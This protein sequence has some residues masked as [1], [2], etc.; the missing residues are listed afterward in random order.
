MPVDILKLTGDPIKLTSVEYS[1]YIK[2]RTEDSRHLN[3]LLIPGPDFLDI[4]GETQ[5]NQLIPGSSMQIER[6]YTPKGVVWKISVSMH[7]I[8]GVKADFVGAVY[9]LRRSSNSDIAWTLVDNDVKINNADQASGEDC[10]GHATA[11]GFSDFIPVVNKTD[12]GKRTK[13]YITRPIG[14]VTKNE[15]MLR[16][17]H[18]LYQ[19]FLVKTC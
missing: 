2:G 8:H 16:V 11:T 15:S 18:D 5:I 12:A 3:T 6:G 17:H 9:I 7:N 1:V 13:G 10:V 19:R 4:G 14:G